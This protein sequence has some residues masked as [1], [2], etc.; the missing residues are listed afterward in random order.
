[1]SCIILDKAVMAQT[2]NSTNNTYPLQSSNNSL[3]VQQ[4]LKERFPTYRNPSLGITIDY[5]PNWGLPSENSRSVTFSAPVLNTSDTFQENLRITVQPSTNR[6]LD[7]F[8]NNDTNSYRDGY[9]DFKLLNKSTNTNNP[10]VKTN[11]GE[12]IHQTGEVVYKYR[13]QKG[14]EYIIRKIFAI[15][16]DKI[17]TLTYSAKASE[18]A[19]YLSSVNE[20][21]NSF[22]LIHFFL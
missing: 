2:Q 16:D 1:M 15:N 10:L 19:N 18:Y 7:D 8:V 14:Q 4:Q 13:D 5:P 9:K 12:T 17:Y 22:K 20:M 21:I 11:L 6:A 3:L